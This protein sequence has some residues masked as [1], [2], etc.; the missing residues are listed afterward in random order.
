MTFLNAAMPGCA[1]KCILD[2]VVRQRRRMPMSPSS[3]LSECLLAHAL[4][5]REIAR[6]CVNEQIAAELERLA[7]EC[8]QAAAKA[9]PAPEQGGRLH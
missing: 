1:H 6:E 2:A 4:L 5:C 8:D 7:D 3:K 9:P